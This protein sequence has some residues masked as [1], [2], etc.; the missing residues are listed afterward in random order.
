MS[1]VFDGMK[2]N[3]FN[4]SLIKLLWTLEGGFSASLLCHGVAF[5]IYFGSLAAANSV[6]FGV[7]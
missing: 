1:G 3:L 2:Q 7:L 6:S 4:L 5:G